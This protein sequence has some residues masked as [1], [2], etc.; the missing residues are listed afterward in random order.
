M[1]AP[2]N[3]G[4]G[5]VRRILDRLKA[6]ECRNAALTT[7]GTAVLEVAG[8]RSLWAGGRAVVGA[9][10]NLRTTKRLLGGIMNVAGARKQA[11]RTLFSAGRAYVGGLTGEGAGE[12]FAVSATALSGSKLD[13][14]TVLGFVPAP[15]AGTLA[16]TINTIRACTK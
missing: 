4:H 8:A 1:P 10:R 16:G 14:V 7:V 5:L 2:R 3:G 6:P 12:A 9:F 13:W 11:W 15:G